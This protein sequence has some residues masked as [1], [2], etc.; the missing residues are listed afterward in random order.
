MCGYEREYPYREQ[1]KKQQRN[2]RINRQLLERLQNSTKEQTI[3]NLFAQLTFLQN[4]QKTD[5][6]WVF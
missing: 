4:S 5:T 2:E 1:E 6:A 3:K